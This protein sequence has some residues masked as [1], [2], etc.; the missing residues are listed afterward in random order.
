MKFCSNCGGQIPEGTSFCPTCGAAVPQTQQ[1]QQVNP[2]PEQV[3]QQ[4][5]NQG[6]VNPGQ[7]YAPGQQPAGGADTSTEKI[8]AIFSYIGF[9][10]L[11]F[12][13]GKIAKTPFGQFHAKQASNLFI[14]SFLVSFGIGIIK[15]V[16]YAVGMPSFIGSLLGLVSTFIWILEL[17]GL[18]YACQGKM[19]KVPV[20]D[21]FEIIK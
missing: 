5:F 3:N 13:F 12:H 15:T 16:L 11:I 9:L 14:I 10:G 2:Q 1:A 4:Q 17:I 8:I 21:K 6:Q 19:E 20:L 18:V 7:Q